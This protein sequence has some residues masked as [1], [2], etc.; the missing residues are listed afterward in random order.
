MSLLSNVRFL[1][2]LQRTNSVGVHK[3]IIQNYPFVLRQQCLFFTTLI[4]QRNNMI[5]PLEDRSV[6]SFLIPGA[7]VFDRYF[8]CP[9]GM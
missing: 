2:L 8:N 7:R 5:N 9:L 4:N 1:S 6:E 3:K